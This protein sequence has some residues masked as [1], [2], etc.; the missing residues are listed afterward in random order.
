MTTVIEHN[1]TTPAWELSD[2][3][4][5]DTLPTSDM[6]SVKSSKSR[7]GCA[8]CKKKRM[9]CDETKP[10]CRN[11]LNRDRVCPGYEKE[12]KWKAKCQT[13]VRTFTTVS[14]KKRTGL[15]T[16]SSEKTKHNSST[17]NESHVRSNQAEPLSQP[18]C[19]RAQTITENMMT[20]DTAREPVNW[21]L[22]S[23][24]LDGLSIDEL[25]AMSQS[26]SMS[27]LAPSPLD[28]TLQANSDISL[29]CD[30]LQT[31][32]AQAIGLLQSP[33]LEN[34]AETTTAPDIC[35]SAI[36]AR[37]Q[38]RRRNNRELLAQ[39]YASTPKM[40]CPLIH[41]T[42]RLVEY[43]FSTTCGIYSCFDSS[44]NPFR[45]T[46]SQ[47]WSHSA[48]T[49][50]AIQSMAAAHLANELPS[51]RKEGLVLHR[52]ASKHLEQE[53][54]TRFN[55]GSGDDQPLLSLLLLGLSACWQQAGNLGLLY[56]R[57][58]RSFMLADLKKRGQTASSVAKRPILHLF[59]EA[60]IYWE[61]VT[62]FVAGDNDIDLQAQHYPEVHNTQASA[63]ELIPDV[64]EEYVTPT[65][66]ELVPHPWTGVSPESQ[67]LLGQVGRLVRQ[68]RTQV[69]HQQDQKRYFSLALELEE[70]L[71]GLQLP[72]ITSMSDYGDGLT[73][74]V[75]F[76]T[77]AELTRYAGLLELYRVFP[78]LLQQRLP[79]GDPSLTN[80][81]NSNNN[82]FTS[83]SEK[84]SWL[85]SLAIH[86]FT[87]LETIPEH[88]N[89]HFHQLLLIVIAAAELRFSSPGAVAATLQSS[90]QDAQIYRARKFVRVRLHQLAAQLP[91][92]PVYVIIELV[93]EVWRRL[94][95]SS[96]DEKKI[97][98]VFWMDVMIEKGWE[99]I[100]G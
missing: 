60:M 57:T 65:T 2:K 99:T 16:S 71:L 47:Q 28:F 44:L 4:V 42:T 72:Q 69:S 63:D 51:M 10:E 54:Q 58:A 45:Y 25:F 35:A 13:N 12:L 80:S 85:T 66:S 15:R 30:N 43:Y 33:T 82:I 1:I 17:V 68:V 100:M 38:G 50:Y 62:S 94:D 11:C 61:M 59:E 77:L 36:V 22:G 95:A 20:T 91:A 76:I 84:Q 49:Y 48:S 78:D 90:E 96:S 81:T 34:L 73:H 53:L 14:G 3:M 75:E 89:V 5:C 29:F 83:D 92:Q 70:N 6:P 18:I 93:T 86:I 52:K 74:N 97:D 19:G 37:S 32:S 7:S 27:D 64:D 56:L 55:Q 41:Y 23:V 39:F 21:M 40:T 88:S 98:D 67:M 79:Y 9:K 31:P 46:V 24:D 26:V 87:R 8:F